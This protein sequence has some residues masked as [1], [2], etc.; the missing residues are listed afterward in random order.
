MPSDPRFPVRK[1]NLVEEKD[2]Q[3]NW[4][5]SD[6]IGEYAHENAWED[7]S[8]MSV[9]DVEQYVDDLATYKTKGKKAPRKFT[10]AQIRWIS[11]QMRE[12]RDLV[13]ETQNSIMDA[14]TWM[15]EAAYMPQKWDVLDAMENAKE[16]VINNFSLNLDLWEP[17]LT[18]QQRR[19]GPKEWSP[20]KRMEESEILK[21][22]LKHVELEQEEGHYD[23]YLVF[24]FRSSQAVKDLLSRSTWAE[25]DLVYALQTI[26]FMAIYNHYITDLVDGLEQI[27]EDADISNRTDWRKAWRS[28]LES[29][30]V[31]GVQKEMAA[32]I[33]EM[34]AED[35]D[36]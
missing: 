4:D 17:V 14:L 20:R 25:I 30:I 16:S 8:H 13:E 21:D 34:P 31:P 18:L 36:A 24:D 9:E 2:W 7:F 22:L 32:A 5:P 33:K 15:Y 10:Q 19:H 27:M 11:E 23:R 29:G 6:K 26:E 35:D 3:K 12:R 28:M 1:V